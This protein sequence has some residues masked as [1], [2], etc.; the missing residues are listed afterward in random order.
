MGGA[1]IMGSL[2]FGGRF[3]SRQKNIQAFGSPEIKKN[4]RAV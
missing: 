4:V 3:F 2:S 1:K